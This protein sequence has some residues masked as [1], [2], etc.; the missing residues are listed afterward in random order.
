[1]LI[2]R[3][4]SDEETSPH[5]TSQIRLLTFGLLALLISLP[6]SIYAAPKRRLQIGFVSI[7]P[8]IAPN[9]KLTL[10]LPG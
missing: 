6:S 3:Q 4:Q 7:V 2:V 10:K 1:M 8:G 9:A 5:G